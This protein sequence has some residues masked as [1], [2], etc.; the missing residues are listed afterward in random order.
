M[1]CAPS[2]L[3]AICLCMLFTVSLSCPTDSSLHLFIT[4]LCGA[5]SDSP[6]FSILHGFLTLSHLPDHHGNSSCSLVVQPYVFIISE[7]YAEIPYLLWQ[8]KLFVFSVIYS[9][10]IMDSLDPKPLPSCDHWW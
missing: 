10:S 6:Y 5:P 1:L 3:Y 8:S 7:Y 4:S 2:H 9:Q